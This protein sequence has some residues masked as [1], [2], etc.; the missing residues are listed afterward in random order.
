M[1][2]PVE[3]GSIH[4]NDVKKFASTKHKG[5]PEKKEV[6]EDKNLRAGNSKTSENGISK[7]VVMVPKCGT[8]S[9]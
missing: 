1:L 6:K 7:S 5:L 3:K 8:C 9:P 2:H 4:E